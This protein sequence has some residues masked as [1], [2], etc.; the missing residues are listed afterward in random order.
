MD[1]VKFLEL[2]VD[3]RK[4][5]YYHL[6]YNFGNVNPQAS[7]K[8]YTSDN[9][10][11]VDIK[12]EKRGNDKSVLRVF[13]SIFKPYF[14]MF[15]HTPSIL[16]RWVEYSLWLRYDSITLDCLRLNHTYQG[17]LLGPLDWIYLDK[18]LRISYF[19]TNGMLQV[20]YTSKEFNRWII[21]GNPYSD[22]NDALGYFRFSFEYISAKDIG[23]SINVFKKKDNFQD[24]SQILFDEEDN[25]EDDLKL[26]SNEDEDNTKILYQDKIY[27]NQLADPTLTDVIKVLDNMK[28]LRKLYVR[29]DTLY[30]T[31]INLQGARD[32][33]GRTISHTCRKRINEIDIRR[34]HNITSTKSAVFSKWNNLR[35]LTLN[36]IGNIDFNKII[37]PP[38]CKELVVNHSTSVKWWDIK[39]QITMLFPK[40]QR[41]NL[42]IAYHNRKNKGPKSRNINYYKLNKGILDPDAVLRAKVMMKEKFKPLNYIKLQNILDMVDSYVIVPSNIFFTN[43]IKIFSSESITDVYIV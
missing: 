41:R 27:K 25:E 18:K 11:L 24:I 34:V 32:N 20:W 1:V 42:W 33:P 37:L 6:S 22:S 8:L 38:S 19:D 23:R 16:E 13:R 21:N 12:K 14:F 39:D 29:N 4:E 35:K 7:E 15:D 3:I 17:E 36:H 31:L 5:V 40:D 10:Q 30:Q 9:V 2:P 28:N 26:L 43:R